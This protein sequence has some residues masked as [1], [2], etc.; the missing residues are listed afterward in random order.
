SPYGLVPAALKGISAHHLLR[1]AAETAKL[2]RRNS[3]LDS[4]PGAYLGAILGTLA[5]KGRDKL[6]LILSSRLRCF[7]LWLEQLIAESTGKEGQGIL[8]VEGER[9]GGPEVYGDDRFIVVIKEKGGR[10]PQAAIGRLERAGFP[11]LSVTIPGF[12]HLGGQFFLWELAT[13]IAAFFFGINPFDQPDVDSAKKRTQEFLKFYREKGVLPQEIPGFIQ[14]EF[15]LYTD[16]E[17]RSPQDCFKSFL[18]QAKPGDY[19]ALQAFLDD[20]RETGAALQALRHEV[21]T[22]T[23]LATTLGYGPRFLHSTG[24]LHKGG[25][26][27]GLFIQIT[28]DDKKDAAIPGEPGQAASE[29]TFGVLKAAQALGDFAALKAAGRRVIRFHLRSGTAAGLQRIGA[30]LD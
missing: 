24:Q 16:I 7:G 18:S 20:N 2:C 3:K 13:A 11:V 1:R 9:V 26:G 5:K 28:A 22:R 21:Q 27:N 30:F 12:Y 14:K 6:T 4:N 17:G 29:L 15:A 25:R 23:R 8:P 10:V 19:V